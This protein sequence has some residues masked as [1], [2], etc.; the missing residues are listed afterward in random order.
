M[1]PGN[2]L[3]QEHPSASANVPIQI[4][5]Q[6]ELGGREREVFSP[7]KVQQPVRRTRRGS[8]RCAPVSMPYPQRMWRPQHHA[9]D[10]LNVLREQQ[11]SL[12][13][14]GRSKKLHWVRISDS[15]SVRGN[16][17]QIAR[18]TNFPVEE[19]FWED[20]RDLAKAPLKCP[21]SQLLDLASPALLRFMGIDPVDGEP[22][23]LETSGGLQREV[24]GERS[25]SPDSTASTPDTFIAQ[26][27]EGS[28][29]GADEGLQDV[30]E[31]GNSLDAPKLMQEDLEDAARLILLIHAQSLGRNVS[32]RGV[33][34]FLPGWFFGANEYYL[35]YKKASFSCLTLFMP[36]SERRFP[37]SFRKREIMRMARAHT[38]AKRQAMIS[39][40]SSR[41]SL[42]YGAGTAQNPE[43]LVQLT[44]DLLILHIHRDAETEDLRRAKQQ[45]QGSTC[46]KIIVATNIAESSITFA[47]VSIV[48]DFA[49]VK[50]KHVHSLTKAH[51][52]QLCWASRAALEQRKGRAGRVGEEVYMCLI[53]RELY[54]SLAGL[55]LPE[56]QRLPL[57]DADVLRWMRTR[58]ARPAVAACC[59]EMSYPGAFSAMQKQHIQ[60]DEAKRFPGHAH[61][62]QMCCPRDSEFSWGEFIPCDICVNVLTMLRLQKQFGDRLRHLHAYLHMRGGSYRG[63]QP[64]R[65]REMEHLSRYLSVNGI[66]L[67]A[68]ADIVTE[69][70]LILRKSAHTGFSQRPEAARATAVAL[71]GLSPSERF[72][73]GAGFQNEI[74]GFVW[75]LQLV[76][77]SAY[78]P[79]GFS[80]VTDESMH[81]PFNLGH[82]LPTH[83]AYNVL[84]YDAFRERPDLRS[85]E[86]VF[87]SWKHDLSSSPL[88]CPH[89]PL[90][91]NS[92]RC[93][94]FYRFYEGGS[95]VPA[96]H[97]GHL[98]SMSD[99]SLEQNTELNAARW[100]Q[101]ELAKELQLLLRSSCS[102][103]F[104]LKLSAALLKESDLKYFAASPSHVHGVAW[105]LVKNSLGSWMDNQYRVHG[106]LLSEFR[107][108]LQQCDACGAV[109]G[110]HLEDWHGCRPIKHISRGWGFDFRRAPWDLFGLQ[111]RLDELL[112]PLLS[113]G[114]RALL[115]T[116]IRGV[117][118]AVREFFSSRQI[119]ARQQ[120]A[121]CNSKRAKGQG[122]LRYVREQEEAQNNPASTWP[123]VVDT[124]VDSLEMAVD[125]VTEA[126]DF[127]CVER[128]FKASEEERES[129]G[130]GAQPAP[131]S[132][133]ADEVSMSSSDYTLKGPA[134]F[135]APPHHSKFSRWETKDHLPLQ[136]VKKEE[137]PLAQRP[138]LCS[139]QD[140][141]ERRGYVRDQDRSGRHECTGREAVPVYGAERCAMHNKTFFS[142]AHRFLEEFLALDAEAGSSTKLRG[143]PDT[144]RISRFAE[145]AILHS[146]G[147]FYPKCSTRDF[148]VL[149]LNEWDLSCGG[150]SRGSA[151][152]AASLLPPLPYLEE[153]L[154]FLLA[155]ATA[156][157][158]ADRC[159]C[160]CCKSCPC[161]PQCGL[162]AD[163]RNHEEGQSVGSATPYT[164]SGQAASRIC[165][166]SCL[167][168]AVCYASVS[169]GGFRDFGFV[170]R[171]LWKNKEI[172][173][174]NEARTVLAEIFK[175]K[176]GGAEWG[177]PSSAGA[178]TRRNNDKR[179]NDARLAWASDDDEDDEL[180][181]LEG[182]GEA[183]EIN[184]SRN[185]VEPQKAVPASPLDSVL[186]QLVLPK[187]RMQFQQRL[188]ATAASA[189]LLSN[190]ELTGF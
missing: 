152:G 97:Q 52:L 164:S 51:R 113:S 126:A 62:P 39:L 79:F 186:E 160:Y 65:S 118:E 187:M 78:M 22:F 55:P 174:L 175:S 11:S 17:V 108:L 21:A 105:F 135:K 91:K 166:S 183:E 150:S 19:L 76:L 66:S 88:V 162:Q 14:D 58:S 93:A 184:A 10:P 107:R 132:R 147:P 145:Q 134:T 49:L 24:R 59:T 36:H 90:E 179:D 116:D 47:D 146:N 2:H 101:L 84:C 169:F 173:L 121:R 139:S 41:A 63:Q 34:V 86:A 16:C 4:S 6:E 167:R 71:S 128:F 172:A 27:E 109:E 189:K 1:S 155:P 44:M 15:A 159:L 133:P 9:R 32:Q 157:F 77:A 140:G 156:M 92:T 30:N 74:E 177:S 73:S 143:Q 35:Y 85:G 54:E 26:G 25:F 72:V 18:Q 142:V 141:D 161:N 144:A 94:C 7:L 114:S 12:L 28:P 190:K 69:Y 87:E 61:G 98:E 96:L 153:L 95:E 43:I 176:V 56:L 111:R 136:R 163:G 158:L 75:R 64:S 165:C 60:E 112:A 23:T 168:G 3:N 81:A 45:M 48:I 57:E 8:V 125:S 188:A 178:Q 13:S 102:V 122:R 103:A 29:R 182:S 80:T 119:E 31:G 129:R 82:Q 120:Q 185:A 68:V 171:F 83:F 180:D 53:T 40:R 104:R 42:K 115:P 50:E 5:N 37:L 151:V 124:H 137:N 181:E 148:L 38:E 33:L 127:D 99:R 123:S 106:T 67:H 154:L 89:T 20:L 170:P 130:F 149:S 70:Y 131:T 138:N 100:S 117:A 46:M 110:L